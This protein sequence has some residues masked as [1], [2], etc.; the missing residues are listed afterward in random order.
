MC[1]IRFCR[2]AKT[3]FDQTFLFVYYCH[4]VLPHCWQ[5]PPSTPNIKVFVCL[6]VFYFTL[7]HSIVL[8]NNLM[9]GQS[10]AYILIR[11]SCSFSVCCLPLTSTQFIK[12]AEHKYPLCSEL[13]A[14][15]LCGM[16][17]FFFST[18]IIFKIL[19]QNTSSKK[20]F[21]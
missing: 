4:S 7:Y 9:W 20:Y 1:Y 2:K 17:L 11:L 12:Q 15:K 6:F 13:G 16:F 10:L 3:N 5:Y 21:S 19:A 8:Y 14:H 18:Q